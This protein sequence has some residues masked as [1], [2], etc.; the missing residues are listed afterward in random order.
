MIDAQIIVLLSALKTPP[1]TIPKR[2]M[3]RTVCTVLK[4]S[5]EIGDLNK[6]QI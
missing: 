1:K 3:N 4:L 2:M 5:K 6:V